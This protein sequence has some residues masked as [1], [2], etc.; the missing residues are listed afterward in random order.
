MTFALHH[1]A[2]ND[3]NLVPKTAPSNYNEKIMPSAGDCSIQQ[4]VKDKDGCASITVSYTKLNE[5]IA[6]YRQQTREQLDLFKIT[7]RYGV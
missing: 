4:A 1:I 7:V 5:Q 2:L 3:F 6:D